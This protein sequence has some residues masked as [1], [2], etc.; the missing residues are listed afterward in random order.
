VTIFNKSSTLFIDMENLY[1][2]LQVLGKIFSGMFLNGS[3]L[4]VL[5]IF[6]ALGIAVYL[7]N[8]QEN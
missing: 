3:G 5:I 1:L 2:P 8:H 4:A 6:G 7:A